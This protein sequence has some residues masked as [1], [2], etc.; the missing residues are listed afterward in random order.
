MKFK[1]ENP[2]LKYGVFL[3]LTAYLL[4][5]ICS[6]CVKLLGDQFPTIEIVF[7]QSI[8]PLIC[9]APTIFTHKL[10][11]LKPVSIK[12]HL[13]RDISGIAS[14]FAYF[15]AIKYLGLVDA[16]VLTYTAPF[17]IPIIWSIW[18][19]EKISKNVWWTILLGFIGILFILKPGP[20]IIKLNS[21]I[22][23]LA[24]ILSALALA[25]ISM[26]NKKRELLTNILFYNFLVSALIALPFALI[27]WQAP[28]LIEIS[29]LLGVGLSTFLGQILL[30]EAYRHGT[31][32]FL[33]PLSYS[34]VIYTAFIS[35]GL[36][37]NPPGWLS[38][39]GILFVVFG[40]TL[41]FIFRE[42]PENVSEI[43]TKTNSTEAPPWWKVWK[44]TPKK[45]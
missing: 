3:T 21:F 27:T 28:S 31:A 43:F 37:K 10:Y 44:K 45:N 24:G 36:L 2:S 17:Y 34:I 35:W 32:S 23:I 20:G 26:L 7:F 22:G 42:K 8:I 40:G 5:A 19:K 38:F 13:I 12:D 33:S 11:L 41:S 16:T 39:I 9:I 14:Y 15:F 30:T 29:L 4:F 1:P 6:T 18:T 25:A